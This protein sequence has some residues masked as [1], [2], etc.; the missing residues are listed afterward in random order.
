M[1]FHGSNNQTDSVRALK[2]EL[3]VDQ[4]LTN[5]PLH[6]QQTAVNGD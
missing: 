6:V 2:E 1:G 5:E 3:D 4:P